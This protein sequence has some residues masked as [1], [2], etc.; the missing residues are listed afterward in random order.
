MWFGVFSVGERVDGSEPDEGDAELPRGRHAGTK[1]AALR[2]DLRFGREVT[3]SAIYD[4]IYSLIDV[5]IPVYSYQVPGT[6][7]VVPGMYYPL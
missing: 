5:Y 1:G 3:H 4:L 6:C 7:F 2:Q